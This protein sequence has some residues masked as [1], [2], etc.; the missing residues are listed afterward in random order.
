MDG[1]SAYGHKP[2]CRIVRNSG[3]VEEFALTTFHFTVPSWT[4]YVII[5]MCLIS[6]GLNAAQIYYARKDRNVK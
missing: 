3:K 1:D 4:I 5:A 6:A 2:C